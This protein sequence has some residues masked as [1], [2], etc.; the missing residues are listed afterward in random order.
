MIISVSFKVK[1]SSYTR[2]YLQPINAIMKA[3]ILTEHGVTKW[4]Y[5]LCPNAS[6]CTFLQTQTPRKPSK[7]VKTRR[8]HNPKVIGSSPVPATEKDKFILFEF[9]LFLCPP[10]SRAIVGD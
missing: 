2:Y 3:Q 4:C 7:T 6:K 10:V 1:T 5:I 9:V 8:A